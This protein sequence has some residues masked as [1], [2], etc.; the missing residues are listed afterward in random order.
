MHFTVRKVTLKRRFIFCGKLL[1]VSRNIWEEGH[2]NDR[3]GEVD[4]G[5]EEG[6]GEID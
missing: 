2:E 4:Q 1:E 3:R 6:M 5:K